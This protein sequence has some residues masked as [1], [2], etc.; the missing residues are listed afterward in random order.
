[1]QWSD[2]KEAY[3][4]QQFTLRR[5][6][7]ESISKIPKE[8]KDE[9]L[10][11]TGAKES[12][13]KLIH[14]FHELELVQCV[15]R[16]EIPTKEVI[17]AA[18]YSPMFPKSDSLFMANF[19]RQLTFY[20][21]DVVRKPEANQQ[22]NRDA[23]GKIMLFCRSFTE[24]YVNLAQ[25]TPVDERITSLQEWKDFVKDP[26]SLNLAAKVGKAVSDLGLEIF[27]IIA[28]QWNGT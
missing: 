9:V 13:L 25:Y 15:N 26:C 11:R 3:A 12:L 4:G 28:M 7:A 20:I 6:H 24:K 22:M 10:F 18:I 17:I 19:A 5:D 27:P 16:N 1:M 14:T 21:Q 23:A 2:F 8:L